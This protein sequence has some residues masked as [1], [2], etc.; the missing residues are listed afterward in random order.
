MD[1]FISLTSDRG[2]YKKILKN[3]KGQLPNDSSKLLISSQGALEDGTIFDESP[4]D[5]RLIDLSN[6]SALKGILIALKTMQKGEK[7][8]FV[9]RDDYAFG[10]K[11]SLNVPPNSPLIFCIELHE[12]S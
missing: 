10:E 4:K 8:I 3:G 5:G 9:M 7:S 1:Q 11:G 6:I 2:L 12:I